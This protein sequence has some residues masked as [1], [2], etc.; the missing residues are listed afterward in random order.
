MTAIN[1]F[2]LLDW[3][4]A[5]NGEFSQSAEDDYFAAVEASEPA[6]PIMP[7]STTRFTR[8]E[9]H[10]YQHATITKVTPVI[11]NTRM[12]SVVHVYHTQGETK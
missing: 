7:V 3:L 10:H 12:N 9:I 5:K 11:N 1:D 6:T 4:L 8:T 2:A